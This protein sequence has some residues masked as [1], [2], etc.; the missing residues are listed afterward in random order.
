MQVNLA[1]GAAAMEV[2]AAVADFI[3]E[4]YRKGVLIDALS[5]RVVEAARKA[6]D[7]IHAESMVNIRQLLELENV[8]S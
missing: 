6:A 5:L 7:A 3:A 2:H 1:R 4:E 8:A